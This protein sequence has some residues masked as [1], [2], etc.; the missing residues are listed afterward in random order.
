MLPPAP[1]I[2]LANDGLEAWPFLRS[3]MAV[4]RVSS[5]PASRSCG[6]VQA[7]FGAL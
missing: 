6:K 1:C 2:R 7:G 3:Y 5:L 4:K